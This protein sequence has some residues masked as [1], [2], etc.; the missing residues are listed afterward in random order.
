MDFIDR[1]LM[2]WV[3]RRWGKKNLLAM[4]ESGASERRIQIRRDH[5]AR[6]ERDVR[7]NRI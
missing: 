4:Q 2:A 1:W 6:L 3:I 5:W 7:E